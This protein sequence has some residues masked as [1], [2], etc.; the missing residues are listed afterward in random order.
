M[1]KRKLVA[2]DPCQSKIQKLSMFGF[3]SNSGSEHSTPPA[4]ASN[5]VKIVKPSTPKRKFNIS[6]KF[7]RNWLRYDSKLGLMFCDLCISANVQN[8]FTE[9][10][11]IM[12]KENV[13]KHKKGTGAY[14][15][16]HTFL[17][18][19]PKIRSSINN[20]HALYKIKKIFIFL[21]IHKFRRQ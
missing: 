2:S 15:F 9:G 20:L 21:F 1:G 19:Y 14:Y 10:C 11:S 5:S 13:D 6:W 17:H 16:L 7:N 8:V 3:S 18:N 4:Q 12:K